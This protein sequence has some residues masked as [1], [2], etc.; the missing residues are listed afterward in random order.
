M[1]HGFVL[2]CSWV[3]NSECEDLVRELPRRTTDLGSLPFLEGLE[4]RMA[5]VGP[6]FG[7]GRHVWHASQS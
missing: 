1:Y 5:D 2:L 4:Q 7:D 6:Y 3:P